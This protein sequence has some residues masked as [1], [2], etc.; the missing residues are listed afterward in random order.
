M[1][2]SLFLAMSATA[3][4]PQNAAPSAPQQALTL[5][6]LKHDLLHADASNSLQQS[7]SFTPGGGGSSYNYCQAV[8]G[9]GGQ[10][11]HIGSSGSFSLGTGANPFVLVVNGVPAAPA[12]FGMFT[13]G[14]VQTNVPFANGTLCI[15]PF[16]PGIHRMTPQS[17]GL[18][19]VTLS[20][21][22][23]PEQ[24]T[25]ITPGSS[26]NFQFWYRDPTAGGANF[27]L[28]DALHVDFAP[29]P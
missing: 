8:E 21:L 28:S 16:T 17:L 27:N 19:S 25:Q 11:A 15:S 10:A 26:W 29:A 20:S 13:Y 12:S 3:L 5:K 2:L 7:G 22:T 23:H 24:F 18:G 9:S 1:I 4:P 6:Q 14:S